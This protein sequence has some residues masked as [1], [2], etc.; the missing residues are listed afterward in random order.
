MVAG[1]GLRCGWGHAL[2][3]GGGLEDWRTR[4][5]KSKILPVRMEWQ[6]GKIEYAVWKGGNGGIELK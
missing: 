6:Y 1:V 5:S 4:G 2:G 3:P